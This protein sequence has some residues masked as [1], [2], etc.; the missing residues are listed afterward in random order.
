[1]NKIIKSFSIGISLF[2]G[3]T[4][5]MALEINKY[6]YIGAN[7]SILGDGLTAILNE[8]FLIIRIITPILVAA[9]ITKDFLMA[10]TAGKEDDIKKAQT[11]AITRIIVGV[12]IFFLPTLIN[13]LLKLASNTF[14]SGTCGIG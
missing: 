8:V 6:V 5:I 2:F 4:Q 7:C 13:I 10:V 3:Q 9:L 14:G 1:M 12:M 11:A